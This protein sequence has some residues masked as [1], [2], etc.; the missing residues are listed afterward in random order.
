MCLTTSLV[1]QL[2]LEFVGEHGDVLDDLLH[3]RVLN[4]DVS[5][6]LH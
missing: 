6:S 1:L 4:E 5:L 3:H 2:E